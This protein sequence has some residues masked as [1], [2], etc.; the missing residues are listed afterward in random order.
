ML[1]V[2]PF[3]APHLEQAVHVMVEAFTKDRWSWGRA[4]ERSPDMMKG[5]MANAYLPDRIREGQSLVALLGDKVIGVLAIESF[6]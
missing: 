4:L 6:N 3:A 2:A 1:R 5:W